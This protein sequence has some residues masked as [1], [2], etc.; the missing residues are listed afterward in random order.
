MTL[1][2]EDIARPADAINRAFRFW[3]SRF[4]GQGG[5]SADVAK[6]ILRVLAPT[7]SVVRS[8][9][10]GL[11]ERE[12]VFVQLTREQSRVLDFLEPDAG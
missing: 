7:L 4:P 9:R 2:A 5:A 1:D 10:Q 12:D 3:R 6:R 8:V 11:D